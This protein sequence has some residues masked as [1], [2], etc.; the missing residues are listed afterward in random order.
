MLFRSLDA[1]HLYSK[2]DMGSWLHL[3]IEY[4][5]SPHWF[6]SVAD[7]WNYGN[8]QKEKKIHYF[9][10]A[11]TYIIKTTRISLQYGKTREGILCSGGVCRTV[12]ASYGVALSVITSF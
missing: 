6:F 1:Q 8:S 2:Q 4:S 12:P 7:A 3:L 9:N 11:A 10:V 5:I